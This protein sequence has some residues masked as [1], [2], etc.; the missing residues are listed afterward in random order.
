MPT[1][2]E[3]IATNRSTEEICNEIGADY[4]IFQ[5]L[6]ALNHAVS[7][8]SSVVRNFETSCF[9]G[10]YITGDVTSEYLRA[11]EL[12]RNTDHPFSQSRSNTQLDLSLV[13]SD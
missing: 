10:D 1:R 3:L 4:L 7:K 13:V 12:Q 5:D 6:D 2:Q 8:V 11:I 9:N